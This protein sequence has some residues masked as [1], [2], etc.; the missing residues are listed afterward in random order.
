MTWL[1]VWSLAKDLNPIKLLRGEIEKREL[2]E[3]CRD[4]EK[5]LSD[6][7]REQAESQ[8]QIKKLQSAIAASLSFEYAAPGY[9]FFRDSIVPY[10]ATCFD[11]EGKRINLEAREEWNGGIRRSCPV[12]SREY[13]DQQPSRES[14]LSYYHKTARQ[15][16]R[17]FET[18]RNR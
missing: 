9:V 6:S 7:E 15:V 14:T 5:R 18:T 12:C 8:S 3:C 16:I 10:C 11:N 1:T 17:E 13:W 4:L 2:R